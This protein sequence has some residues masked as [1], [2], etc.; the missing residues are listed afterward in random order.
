MKPSAETGNASRR[1]SATFVTCGP[2]SGTN[3]ALLP[4]LAE[5]LGELEIE[6]FDV[7]SWLRQSRRRQFVVGT[8]V[9]AGSP[10]ALR[11]RGRFRRA[12]YRSPYLANLIRREAQELAERRPRAFSLQTQSLF[13]ASVPGLPHFVY[14]DDTVLANTEYPGFDPAQVDRAWVERERRI[15]ENA[16]VTFT[17]GGHVSRSLVE[18]YGIDPDRVLEVGAG[19]NVLPRPRR[20]SAAGSE[21][22]LF[23]GREWER[24]GG[25]ELAAAMALLRRQRPQASLVVAGCSPQLDEAAGARVLGEVGSEVVAELFADAAVLCMPTRI[26]PFGLVFIEALSCGVPVV[27]TDLGAL[28]DIVTDGESGYLVGI[29]DPPALAATLER[30]L[31]DPERNRRFGEAGRDHVLARF[32]WPRVAAAMAAMI[33]AE[34]GGDDGN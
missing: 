18:H 20:A 1:R 29:D 11:E 12:L 32:T 6:R 31:E 30:L 15:Y 13:D 7:T 26:E 10:A 21:T 19:G 4:L 27:A 33:R 16:R 3:E 34:I 2:F 9:L 5:A 17:M 25:P 23:V 8:H 24:K 14:T 28:R 22:V